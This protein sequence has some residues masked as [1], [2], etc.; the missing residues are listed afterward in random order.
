MKETDNE[1]PFE[2]SKREIIIQSQCFRLFI[3]TPVHHIS[4]VL[5]T[6]PPNLIPGEILS[7]IQMSPL[8]SK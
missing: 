7:S 3:K 2:I 8:R 5:N 4:N 6:P 1:Y